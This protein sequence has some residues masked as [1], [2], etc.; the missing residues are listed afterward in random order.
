[1][2]EPAVH[3]VEIEALRVEPVAKPF[4]ELIVGIVRNLEQL[5]VPGHPAT[6][7]RRAGPLAR[8]ADRTAGVGVRIG[9]VLD[10]NDV[11]S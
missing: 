6:V 1:M 10:L 8:H 9:D 7:L 4:G 3:Q 2:A 5:V 11:V